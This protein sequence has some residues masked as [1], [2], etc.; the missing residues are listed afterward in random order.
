[1]QLIAEAYDLLRRGAGLSPAEIAEIF[2]RVEQGRP[3][4][5]PDRDHR[6]GAGPGRRGRPA[7][8]SWTSCWTRPGRRAPGPGPCRPR[9]T[10]ASRSPASPRRCSPAA[11]SV[12]DAAAA[13]AAG[14]LPGPTTPDGRGPGRVRRGRPACAV[15]VEDRRLRAGLRRDP[16][17]AQRSTAGTSTSVRWPRIWRGGCIIRANFLNRITEA[18]DARART[19]RSL[20]L[21]PYFTDAITTAQDAWRRVVAGAAQSASRPPASPPRCRTTTGCGPSGCRRR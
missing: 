5:V 4:F 21:A 8:R 14:V 6:R 12:G 13:A 15:R 16:R 17:P 3:G 7:S 18:Y 20:L 10:W 2:A 1:M 9:W 11:L 19:C